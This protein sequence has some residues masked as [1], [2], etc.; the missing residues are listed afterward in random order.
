MG[1]DQFC[2]GSCLWSKRNQQ[3]VK[4][5]QKKK[6]QASTSG[7]DASRGQGGLTPGG[8]LNESQ[9]FLIC[10]THRYTSATMHSMKMTLIA[11]L[12]SRRAFSI[13]FNLRY[14]ALMR[15]CPILRRI[16]VIRVAMSTGR[17]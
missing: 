12:N 2:R 3:P 10:R 8:I 14:S 9:S 5:C 13:R 1:S 6:D 16:A 7:C 4:T 11:M 15:R 17:E